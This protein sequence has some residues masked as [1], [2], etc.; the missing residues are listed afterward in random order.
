MDDAQEKSDKQSVLCKKT[1]GS[2]TGTLKKLKGRVSEV[3]KDYKE[4][5]DSKL[6]SSFKVFG[7]FSKKGFSMFFGKKKKDK[8]GKEA[9]PGFLGK[10]MGKRQNKY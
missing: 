6:K 9:K 2:I 10:L 7:D 5:G 3:N 8:D 1:Y 4:L